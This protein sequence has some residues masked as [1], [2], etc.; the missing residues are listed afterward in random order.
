MSASWRSRLTLEELMIMRR[1][2]NPGGLWRALRQKV[3]GREHTVELT[4]SRSDL[5]ALL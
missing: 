4:H 2:N 5:L 1:K 3:A